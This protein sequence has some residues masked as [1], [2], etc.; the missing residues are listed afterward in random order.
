M[1]LEGF[2]LGQCAAKQIARVLIIYIGRKSQRFK[3]R[4]EKNEARPSR[5]VAKSSA[6]AQLAE[7]ETSK[8]APII[9][10]RN[11]CLLPAAIE[12]IIIYSYS[13]RPNQNR[14]RK[15]VTQDETFI[16]FNGP[17]HFIGFRL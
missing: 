5:S 7:T 11:T 8:L 10:S 1:G 17:L 9:F 3:T 4:A 13:Y 2:L 16:S 14:T 6:I 15:S 12:S